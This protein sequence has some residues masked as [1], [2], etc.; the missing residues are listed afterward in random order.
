MSRWYAIGAVRFPW[1]CPSW[2]RTL[3]TAEITRFGTIHSWMWSCKRRGI[4]LVIS[5]ELRLRGRNY[6]FVYT[7]REKDLLLKGDSAWT[8]YVLIGTQNNFFI[9]QYIIPSYSIHFGRLQ[10]RHI[11]YCHQVLHLNE[12]RESIIEIPVSAVSESWLRSWGE[13]CAIFVKVIWL[14]QMGEKASG[15]RLNNE[16]LL[17]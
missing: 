3:L 15:R 1:L 12:P 10:S 4:V 17:H 8:K 5:G 7:M 16:L 11:L 13:L 2:E 6:C 9:L 14:K